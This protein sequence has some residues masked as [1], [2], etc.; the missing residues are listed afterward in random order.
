MNF[1]GEFSR[2]NA[3]SAKY[4]VQSTERIIVDFN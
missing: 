2:T 1:R 4:K 3:Q